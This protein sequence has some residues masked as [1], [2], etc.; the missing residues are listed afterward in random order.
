MR[1]LLILALLAWPVVTGAAPEY[2]RMGPDLFDPAADGEALV[3]AAISRTRGEGKHLLLFF[4][5]NWC[6][7]CRRLHRVMA[8]D[9]R[10]RAHLERHFVVVHVDANTRLDRK[11]NAAV[12]ARYGNPLRFGLPVFVVLAPDGT[13]LATRE[14]QSLA[15]PTDAEVAARVAAFLRVWTPQARTAP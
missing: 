8:T 14:T 12:I 2:P 7:W 6:P 15:A 10:I 5:A 11:R 13:L 1:R 3:S 9:S 4:G